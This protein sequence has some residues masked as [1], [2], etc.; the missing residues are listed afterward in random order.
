VRMPSKMFGTK[1][2]P[3]PMKTLGA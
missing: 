3:L 1:I 2:Q